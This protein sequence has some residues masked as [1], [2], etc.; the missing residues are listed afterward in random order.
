MFQ[1]HSTVRYRL[2]ILGVLDSNKWKQQDKDKEIWPRIRTVIV[3]LF[4]D[5]LLGVYLTES[6]RIEY[7][8]I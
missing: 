6:E 8:Y 2:D 1:K 3:L 7:I 4:I 5:N